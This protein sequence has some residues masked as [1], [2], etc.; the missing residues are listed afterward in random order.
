MDRLPVIV[1]PFHDPEGRYFPHFE[2]ITPTLKTLFARAFVSL[3][4][5]TLQAQPERINALRRDSF[6]ELNFNEPGTLA[7]DHYRAAYRRAVDACLPDQVLH[8][9]DVDKV[10][11]VLQSAHRERFLVDLKAASQAASPVLFQRTPAAWA[12]YPKNYREVEHLAIKVAELLFG[13]TID[14]AWSHLVIRAGQLRDILPR[15]RR[16]DFG[17]LAEVVILLKD[18]MIAREVDWLAWEDPF[19]YSRRAGD[20]MKE[21]ESSQEET[22]RRLKWLRPVLQVLLESMDADT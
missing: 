9:C 11:F 21:R 10:I 1:L 20:L 18:G 16:H 4:P 6:F 8:L 22:Q 5:A 17:L 14:V 19:I 2:A 3:S 15:L 12:T 13:R 7:G